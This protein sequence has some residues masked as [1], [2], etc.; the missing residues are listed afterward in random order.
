MNCEIKII[1]EIHKREWGSIMYL[2]PKM[3]KRVVPFSVKNSTIDNTAK[4]CS[5]SEILN[6][7]IGRY[8][9]VGYNSKIYYATVGNYCSIADNVSVGAA[10]HPNTW[11]STSPLFHKG[12]NIFRKNFAQNDFSPYKYTNIGNDVWI[13]NGVKIKSG[14]KIGDGAIVGMGAVVT[15]DVPAYAIVGGGTRQNNKNAFSK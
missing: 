11:V 9:Y 14:I 13:G 12:R 7:K 5:R 3:L 1:D 6:A 10:E 8:S 4:V 15:H 2:L